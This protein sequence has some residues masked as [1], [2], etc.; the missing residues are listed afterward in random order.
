MFAIGF[1]L[2][3]LVQRP[4]S[5][6][7]VTWRGATVREE[8]VSLR[9][10]GGRDSGCGGFAALVLVEERDKTSIPRTE[11]GSTVV[12]SLIQGGV[13]GAHGWRGGQRQASGADMDGGDGTG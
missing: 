6:N 1:C 8:G 12:G 5:A 7:A 11:G 13:R 4:C 2:S 9:G 3:S 10:A